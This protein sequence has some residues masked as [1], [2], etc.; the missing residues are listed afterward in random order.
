MVVFD[1]MWVA[2]VFASCVVVARCGETPKPPLG[3]AGLR[4]RSLAHE[5]KTRRLEENNDRVGV[6][7]SNLGVQVAVVEF[8]SAVRARVVNVSTEYNGALRC[9]RD[10]VSR[11]QSRFHSAA[12][13]YE[14]VSR[15]GFTSPTAETL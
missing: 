15:L 6:G 12:T 13:P 9:N 11:I 3:T 1:L 14:I 7:F 2:D 8:G 10:C 5:E 4:R